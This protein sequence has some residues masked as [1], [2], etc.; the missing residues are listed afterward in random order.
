MIP[1]KK[2]REG[3]QNKIDTTITRFDEK[4]SRSVNTSR[5]HHISKNDLPSVNNIGAGD[6]V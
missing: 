1:P 6:K 3:G 5:V 2:S 4:P